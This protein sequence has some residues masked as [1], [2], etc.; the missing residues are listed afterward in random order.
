MVDQRAHL[1]TIQIIGAVGENL[2][3]ADFF[4]FVAEIGGAG[5]GGLHADLVEFARQAFDFG[6]AALDFGAQGIGRR[7][8][9]FAGQASD[10][11]FELVIFAEMAKRASPVTASILRTPE[12]TDARR[13]A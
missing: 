6:V 7:V 1:R 5:R 3:A 8:G 10:Y 11:A 2:N 13:E 9:L 4:D 12:D